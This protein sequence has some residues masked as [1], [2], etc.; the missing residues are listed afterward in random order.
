MSEGILKV[1]IYLKGWIGIYMYRYLTEIKAKK[2]DV[3]IK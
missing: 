3:K 1:V 2:D